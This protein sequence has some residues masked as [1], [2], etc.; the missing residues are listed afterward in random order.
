[1]RICIGLVYLTFNVTCRALQKVEG[2]Y[3]SQGCDLT[4]EVL[5]MDWDGWVDVGE[6]VPRPKLMGVM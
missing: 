1:M 4:V 3:L 6:K 5:D 2:E